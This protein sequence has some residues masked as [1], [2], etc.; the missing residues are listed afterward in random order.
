MEII[1]NI[2]VYKLA[3]L[4]RISGDSV[5]YQLDQVDPQRRSGAQQRLGEKWLRR[6]ILQ[7]N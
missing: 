1:C 4:L 3:Q 5:R 2:D 7:K 6:F